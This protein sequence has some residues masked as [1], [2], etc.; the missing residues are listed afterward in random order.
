MASSMRHIARTLVTGGA[1]LSLAACG[2]TDWDPFGKAE[3]PLPG[4][5]IAVLV[6]ERTL[7]ADEDVQGQRILLPHPTPNSAWPMAGG[8]AD[9]AMHHVEIPEAI[10]ERWNADIGSGSDDDVRI[11]AQPVVSNGKVFTIDS[12]HTV[13][14]FSRDDG[15]EVWEVDLT[16]DDEDD[17]HIAGGLGYEGGRVYVATGFAEVVAL[18]AE[19]GEVAWRRNVSAPMRAAPTIRDGRVFVVTVDNRVFALDALSG[20]QLWVHEG[21]AETA[22]LLGGAAPAVSG[23]TVI[24]AFTSGDLVALDVSSGRLLW[25][26]SLATVRRTELVSTLAAIRGLPVIDRG[27]VVAISHG[28]IMA[29]IELRTG[30]RVWEREIGGAQTPWVAGD[31]IFVLTNDSEIAALGRNDGKVYWV[32]P[33]PRFEDPEDREGRIVW[34]GP[35]LASDRLLLAG[36]H[37]EVLAASPYDGRILGTAGMPD[38]VSVPPVVADGWVFFLANDAELVAYH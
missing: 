29:A 36:S 20:E 13:S 24:A 22:S 30:R 25:Q 33:L 17:G 10:E 23:S 19:T 28:G 11:T 21:A 34:S 14:A 3:E 15:N 2:I 16:P 8:Y 27:R 1:L 38:G 4:E 26:E 31:F 9:H 35:V 7:S 18:D 6:H 32:R 5:R 37:G 12:D